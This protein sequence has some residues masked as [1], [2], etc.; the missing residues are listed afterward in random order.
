MVLIGCTFVLLTVTEL[1]L[2]VSLPTRQ[3]ASFLETW[4]AR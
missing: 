3:C 4:N 2:H 1:F